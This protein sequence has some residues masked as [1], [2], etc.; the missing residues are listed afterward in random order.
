M[1]S[2]L[3]KQGVTYIIWETWPVM[4]YLSFAIDIQHYLV[5]FTPEQKE[6]ATTNILVFENRSHKIS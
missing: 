2:L 4:S 6:G 3:S 1:T 5:S